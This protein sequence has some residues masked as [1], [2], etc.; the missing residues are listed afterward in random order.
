MKVIFRQISEGEKFFIYYANGRSI[1]YRKHKD[2]K[3]GNN[4]IIVALDYYSN[5]ADA[6]CIGN[7]VSINEY[8]LCSKIHN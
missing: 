6:M 2:I 4:A 5:H 3:T 1:F 7:P 8:Q